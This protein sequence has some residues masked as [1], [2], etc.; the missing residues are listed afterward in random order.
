M[1]YPLR[2][3]ILSFMAIVDGIQGKENG[4]G[5]EFAGTPEK[6]REVTVLLGQGC[7]AAVRKWEKWAVCLLRG[8]CFAALQ[9]KGQENKWL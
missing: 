3:P 2:R 5:S 8:S 6:G 1:A 9:D 7:F 4:G